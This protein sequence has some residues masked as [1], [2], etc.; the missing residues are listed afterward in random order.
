MS[1][2]AGVVVMEHSNLWPGMDLS[3]YLPAVITCIIAFQLDDILEAV[4]PH[5]TIK[6]LLNLIFILAID[7]SQGWRRGMSMTWNWVRE[8]WGQFDNRED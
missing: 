8:R 3:M 6:D 1:S 4:I 2:C 7:D 5:A